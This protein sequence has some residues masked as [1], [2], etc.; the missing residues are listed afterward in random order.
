M[1]WQQ[2]TYGMALA[3]WCNVS[4][5]GGVTAEPY[6]LAMGLRACVTPSWL[7][8]VHPE[9]LPLHP[10]LIPVGQG[11]VHVLLARSSLWF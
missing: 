11:E 6:S 8:Q 1:L 5:S 2:R 4:F 3:S 10:G 7:S 9:G